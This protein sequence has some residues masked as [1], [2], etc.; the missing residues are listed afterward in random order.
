MPQWSD[1]SS[2]VLYPFGVTGENE[3]KLLG[4][5]VHRWNARTGDIDT[6]LL[7]D[8]PDPIASTRVR[9]RGGRHLWYLT[10]TWHLLDGVPTPTGFEVQATN[11][12]PD[13]RHKPLTR[14]LTKRLPLGKITTQ[15]LEQL[16]AFQEG[17]TQALNAN[18]PERQAEA[19]TLRRRTPGYMDDI[20][21]RAYALHATAKN[22]GHP[23]PSLWT[24]EQLGLAGVTNAR[25][26]PPTYQVVRTKWIPK[27][28]VLAAKD[29]RSEQRSG[30]QKNNRKEQGE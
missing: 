29:A 13:D 24:W 8:D 1:T 25:G 10:V 30:D 18:T 22:N 11:G 12:R 27:G 26:E 3:P 14:D 4:T 6:W 23:E 28:K 15:G 16:R 20:Y 17:V 7:D 19:E 9:A 5:S 21:R 2:Y